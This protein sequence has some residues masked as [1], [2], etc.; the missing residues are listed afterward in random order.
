M[1]GELDKETV[2]AL[3]RISY[4]VKCVINSGYN[5][6]G[7]VGDLHFKIVPSLSAVEECN[8]QGKLSRG[9]ITHD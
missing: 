4:T 2:E 6:S 7:K 9:N 8:K 1:N 3:D 5:L